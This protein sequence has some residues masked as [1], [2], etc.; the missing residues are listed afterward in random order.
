MISISIIP[1]AE[2]QLGRLRHVLADV[3]FDSSYPTGGEAFSA[4]SL[5][6]KHLKKIY[7]VQKV[8]GNAASNALLVAWDS[9]NEKL[10]LFYP[11]GGASA[12]A[13][14][15]APAAAAN[16]SGL[17]VTG[18]VTVPAG[19][20]P[21]TSDAAQPDLVETLDVGGTATVALTAG[22]GKELANT[23]DAS[24]ITVRLAIIG[25]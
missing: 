24:T 17:T 5:P 21:V 7:G 1:E 12:P 8:G 25:Y 14:L 6:G 3:T 22:R 11:T 15:A 23:T 2:T 4:A 19:A 20:T 13:A 18:D 9:V 10:Q 16:I